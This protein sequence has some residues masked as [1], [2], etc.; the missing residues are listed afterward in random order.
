MRSFNNSAYLLL[1]ILA[2]NFI[3][4]QLEIA[5]Y[6]APQPN[7]IDSVIGALWVLITMVAY[8]KGR[9]DEFQ[10]WTQMPPL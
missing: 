2:T 7:W 3:W 1:S 4:R 5:A 10:R 9:Y 6:G 8:H